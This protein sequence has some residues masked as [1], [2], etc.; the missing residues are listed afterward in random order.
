LKAYDE[1][2]KT[3]TTIEGAASVE[4]S[5][6]AAGTIW[7]IDA[8]GEV[9]IGTKLVT[10]TYQFLHIKEAIAKAISIGEDGT[11]AVVDAATGVVGL[12]SPDR[13]QAIADA[14]GRAAVKVSIGVKLLFIVGADGKAYSITDSDT[15][16]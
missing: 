3:F 16:L 9:L 7:G 10:G 1:D 11:L 15:S 6:D 12:L 13:T 2:S 4:A 5:V 8:N 14:S